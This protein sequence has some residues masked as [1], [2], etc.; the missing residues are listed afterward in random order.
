VRPKRGGEG[1]LC[2]LS[3]AGQREVGRQPGRL[4]IGLAL[5]STLSDLPY[6]MVFVR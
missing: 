3:T 1:S 6:I 5:L 2:S 4:V